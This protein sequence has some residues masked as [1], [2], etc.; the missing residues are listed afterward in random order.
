MAIELIANRAIAPQRRVLAADR[1]LE[2]RLPGPSPDDRVV[3]RNRT[4]T[5]SAPR[6]IR[7]GRRQ[8]IAAHH[9]LAEVDLRAVD[10]DRNARSTRAR[11]GRNVNYERLTATSEFFGQKRLRLDQARNNIST[12]GLAVITGLFS[13]RLATGH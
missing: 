5:R 4:R 7:P 6:A 11:V 3:A 1:A 13:F 10:V 12:E 9:A 2:Y 8:E